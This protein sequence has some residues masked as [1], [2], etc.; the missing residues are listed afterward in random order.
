MAAPFLSLKADDC[1]ARTLSE[2]CL[3][4]RRLPGSKSLPAFFAAGGVQLAQTQTEDFIMLGTGP[5]CGFS[6][7][8][9]LIFFLDYF[10]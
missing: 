9:S 3:F 7:K 10:H 5:T 1:I 8:T 2:N 4:A 6:Q